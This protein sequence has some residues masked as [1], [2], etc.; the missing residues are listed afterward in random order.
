MEL[1]CDFS[2]PVTFLNFS[3]VTDAYLA[4]CLEG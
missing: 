2:K 4:A 3:P 1:V